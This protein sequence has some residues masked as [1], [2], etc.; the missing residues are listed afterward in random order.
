M[1]RINY[2][3][4]LKY[5]LG[6][7]FFPIFGVRLISRK[8]KSI[9]KNPKKCTENWQSN[10]RKLVQVTTVKN[11]FFF[12]NQKKMHFLEQFIGRWSFRREKHTTINGRSSRLRSV[13]RQFPIY[14]PYRHWKSSSPSTKQDRRREKY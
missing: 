3:V 11:L 14:K 13:Y 5:W 4:Y 6:D 1:K 8:S 2:F 10:R 12:P 9:F 7:H